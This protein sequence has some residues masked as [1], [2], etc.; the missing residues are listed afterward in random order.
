[1]AKMPVWL[2][3][4]RLDIVPDARRVRE[5]ICPVIRGPGKEERSCYIQK[6]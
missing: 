6:K 3:P 4:V 2:P 1:M 5:N